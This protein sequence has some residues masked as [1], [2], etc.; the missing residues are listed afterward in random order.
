MA[1]DNAGQKTAFRTRLDTAADIAD[2]A[3]QGNADDV[4]ASKIPQLDARTHIQPA[5]VTGSQ[6][7]DDSV[8]DP[9]LSAGVQTQLVPGGGAANTVLQKRTAADH[10]DQWGLVNRPNI[11]AD[12]LDRLLPGGGTQGQ[13]LKKQSAT[14]GDADWEAEAAADD[15]ATW[16][17]QGNTDKIPRSKLPAEA[18]TQYVK[19][20][21]FTITVAS[22]GPANEARG[23]DRVVTGGGG[24]AT[25]A[26]WTLDGNQLELIA[27]EQL[28]D[29][30]TS[31][32]VHGTLP[33]NF[34]DR[35]WIFEDASGFHDV[36]RMRDATRYVNEPGDAS[37]PAGIQ[38][39][40]DIDWP[41]QMDQPDLHPRGGF[42]L[43]AVYRY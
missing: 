5:T 36:L 34:R 27:V 28:T 10:D 35:Y 3:E 32:R 26:Q 30:T 17:E 33:S 1:A 4:P 8:D 21:S 15:A 29:G 24:A 13:V 40:R 11:H 38:Q 14:D 41:A 23:F 2:W 31:I 22:L 18:F 25:N 16:A 42:H 7:A 9:Q 20:H 19:E 6:L 43:H 12:V 39:Y 37:Y